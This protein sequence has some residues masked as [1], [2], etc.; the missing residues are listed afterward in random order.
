VLL[1]CLPVL[2]VLSVNGL[3]QELLLAQIAL[4]GSIAPQPAVLKPI[5]SCV[6]QAITTPKPVRQVVTHVRWT[7][8]RT[9]EQQPARIVPLDQVLLL[10]ARQ[11]LH[12]LV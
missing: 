1:P 7:R 11:V 3:L 12:V 10:E 4:Q 8:T 6:V 5:V 9:Q 2:H